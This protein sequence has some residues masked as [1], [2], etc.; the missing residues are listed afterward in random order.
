MIPKRLRISGFLSYQQP[1]EL[2]FDSF[3]LACISGNNGAGKSSLLDAITWVLFGRARRADDALIN[4][5]SSRAEVVFDFEYEQ[6]LYRVQRSKEKDKSTNLELFILDQNNRWRALTE[7]GLRETEKKI[8]QILAMDYETFT[9]ASF[10]LQGKADQFAQ[11]RP[12]ERKRILSNVLGLD[13][14]E[15]Y[16]NRAVELRKSKENSLAGIDSLLAETNAELSEEDQ[17]K[18]KLSALNKELKHL[19]ESRQLKEDSLENNKKLASSVQEQKK[20]VNM[21]FS[22]YQAI[23]KRADGL[24]EDLKIREEGLRKARQALENAAEVQASHKSW[25]ESRQILEDW[26]EKAARHRAL[27]AQRMPLLTE[28][29]KESVRLQQEVQ[30]LEE[31]RLKLKSQENELAVIRPQISAIRAEIEKMEATLRQREIWQTELDQ[32]N[33]NQVGTQAENKRLQAA[34]QE[35]K[36]RIDRLGKAAHDADCPLCG[37][38]L[39][40]RHRGDLI[41]RL[42]QERL[43]FNEQIQNNDRQMRQEKNRADE[44][45]QSMRQLQQAEKTLA[46]AHRQ[47]DQVLNRQETI[48][49]NMQDWQSGGS[50]RLQEAANKLANSTFCETA[51]ESLR[52]LQ[53]EL[54]AVH[55]D[56]KSHQ[57]AK[58]TELAG[59]ASEKALRELEAARAAI[60]PMQREIETLKKQ[61]SEAEKELVSAEAQ[62]H[63]AQ[64]HHLASAKDLPDIAALE[65][66]LL[67]VR[68]EENRLRTQVGG[69]LQAVEVL[70]TLKKRLREY[71]AERE[72]VAKEISRLKQLEQAFGKN[73]VPALL[74][75]QA[76]PEIQNEANEILEKLTNGNMSVIFE[77]QREYKDKKREDKKETL[78]II[79]S[80]ATGTSRDY[81][82]FSGGEAFRVNFAIRL[83]LS[84]FLAQR[85]GARLQ[86]LVIDEGF[87]SQDAEGRQRLVEA[88]N[89]V[90]EHFAKILV[91]THLEELKDVFPARIEVEK[92]LQ[93]SAMKVVA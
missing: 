19:S 68:E 38:T 28:I 2:D 52:V 7:S 50:L 70:E 69:A 30:G 88:I 66:E 35:L 12:N 36:D 41:S 24:R 48:E 59:R 21:L 47:H 51:R 89:L 3:D 27:D 9:N 58:Q 44:I 75:E 23:Q 46:A 31:T 86:T 92:T 90:R 15:E 13:I 34:M 84:R 10:F 11:Q 73:G 77:T 67:I 71:N 5:Q 54:D 1:S 63:D 82:M 49:K 64:Q 81:E 55:Y 93:G 62:H 6:I 78:D 74:I 79:I 26:E 32:L 40:D 45:I 22:Q 17:R 85:A 43:N 87:G 20:L 57:E 4:S 18:E 39:T 61:L 80:D 16:R 29:E 33:E 37:Q 60:D 25:Q 91:I 65:R 72:S 14:W 8:Q 42:E 56:P 76:L 83:A 53:I